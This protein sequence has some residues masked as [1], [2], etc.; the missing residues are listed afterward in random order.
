MRVNEIFYSI[1]GEGLYMNIPMGF[2]R[3]Q[4]CNLLVGCQWCDTEYARDPSE[5]KEMD[6]GEVADSINK[7]T[8]HFG[9]WVC[10]TGGEPL[11]QQDE[12][13]ELVK[14]LKRKYSHKIT[15]ETNGTL[16]K[17]FWYTLVNSWSADIKCPSSGVCG[18]SLIEDWFETRDSDQ[19]K[20]VVGRPE[21]LDF[22]REVVMKNAARSPI[23]IISPI[24]G[25]EA[26]ELSIQ[27]EDE[28][29]EH[30]GGFVLDIEWLG[31]TAE[32]VKELGPYRAR[33]SIQ[34]HKLI[35]G[36]RRGV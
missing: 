20:F 6:V 8:P 17:P 5:G 22:T 1:Q 25:L 29:T 19:V 2:I 4:G 35:W 11:L 30:E 15:I 12:L 7:L 24:V 9:S 34:Q 36:N 18:V 14:V 27:D 31:Q 32:L 10:I 13:Y 26:S 33:L 28:I 3:L 21:D 16:P 23:P